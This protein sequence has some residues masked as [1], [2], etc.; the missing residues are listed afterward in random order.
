MSLPESHTL[1]LHDAL[2]ILIS[3]CGS[4]AEAQASGHGDRRGAAR[5][6]PVAELAEEVVTPT[7][8]RAADREPAS[9]VEASSDGAQRVGT[10]HG[11]RRGAAR[12][13]P[14][15]VLAEA[16]VIPTIPL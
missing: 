7:V 1:S 6:R 15:A 16:V 4:G 12:S 11:D 13:R 5:S 3:T 8:G 9:V 10:R 14:V 2:P